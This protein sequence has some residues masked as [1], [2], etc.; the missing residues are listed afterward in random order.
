MDKTTNETTDVTT[1]PAANKSF[2]SSTRNKIL[3]AV[4]IVVILFA[5]LWIWKG[6]EISNLKEENEKQQ[7]GIRKQAEDFLSQTDTRYLKLVTKPYVWAIRTEMMKGNMEAVNLYANDMIQ[8]KNF[9]MISVV[10]ENGKVVSST[11]KKLEGQ[12]YTP[13]SGKTN[14]TTDST[15]VD[16]I[17]E[18]KVAIASPVMGFN[19][20]IGTVIMVYTPEKLSW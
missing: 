13:V 20:R 6:I 19:K 18:N 9:Q 4:C 12:S 3:V 1:T 8:E 5:A 17:E 11:D 14:L 15:V 16:R 7:A 10:D 2:L